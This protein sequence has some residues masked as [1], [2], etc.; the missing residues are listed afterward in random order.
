[1]FHAAVPRYLFP[2]ERLLR[3]FFRESIPNER[4]VLS[5]KD[6]GDVIT[7]SCLTGIILLDDSR[8]FKNNLKRG[9]D[10]KVR[11][12]GRILNLVTNFFL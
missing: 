10:R 12:N 7:M 11:R 5:C 4:H 1:M 3:L 9:F 2:G 6:S 8:D